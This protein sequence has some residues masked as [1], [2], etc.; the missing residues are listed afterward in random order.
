MHR[1]EVAREDELADD[2]IFRFSPII[3]RK[4]SASSQVR[5]EKQLQSRLRLAVYSR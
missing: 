5:V 1:A 2:R 3:A 4:A